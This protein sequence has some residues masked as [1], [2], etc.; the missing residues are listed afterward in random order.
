MSVEYNTPSVLKYKKF[1]FVLSQ[2]I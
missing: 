2:T 1:S